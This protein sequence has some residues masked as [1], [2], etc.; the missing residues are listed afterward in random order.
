MQVLAS[1]VNFMLVIHKVTKQS[2]AEFPAVG[3]FMEE[4]NNETLNT[5][6]FPEWVYTEK[7]ASR[8][9]LGVEEMP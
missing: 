9:I 8:E 7:W 5:F 3:I 2:A 1:S 4:T 6:Q